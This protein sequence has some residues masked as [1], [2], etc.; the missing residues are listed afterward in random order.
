M[1][2]GLAL[3]IVLAALA[4]AIAIGKVEQQTSYGLN[5]VLGSLG[6]LA[7]AFA[8]WAFQVKK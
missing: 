1:I 8:M 3:L 2:F 4:A 5:I 7:G 6:T